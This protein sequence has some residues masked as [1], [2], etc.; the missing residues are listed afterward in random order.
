[1]GCVD[2]S[3][4]ETKTETTKTRRDEGRHEGIPGFLKW[5]GR[6]ARVATSADKF[7]GRILFMCRVRSILAWIVIAACAAAWA[8]SRYRSDYIAYDGKRRLL[9]GTSEGDIHGYIFPKN[10]QNYRS[11]FEHIQAEPREPTGWWSFEWNKWRRDGQNTPV[12]FVDFR[13]PLWLP[14]L[15][16]VGMLA[17]RRGGWK[18]RRAIGFEVL[19]SE[20]N[21]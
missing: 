14:M 4:R 11:R 2:E 8:S 1:M 19:P 20:G 13:V 21:S 15:C 5:H 3:G 17:Y 10:G 16:C 7:R 12:V 6:L 9:L 18:C